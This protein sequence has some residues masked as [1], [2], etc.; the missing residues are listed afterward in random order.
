MTPTPIPESTSPAETQGG[1]G[2]MD[3]AAASEPANTGDGDAGSGAAGAAP[4]D[5]VA[6]IDAETLEQLSDSVLQSISS[7][8]GRI[9]AF[10]SEQIGCVELQSSFVEVMD[11]WIEYNTRGKG[12]WQGRLPTDLEER[13]ERLYRGV[14]DVERL[15]EGTSCPRP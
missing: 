2:Q 1:T 8:Y 14:Q 6:P 5:I 13:D 12:G 3:E 15:F 9:G 10:D 4:T 11:S 7:F